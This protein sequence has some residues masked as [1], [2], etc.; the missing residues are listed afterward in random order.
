MPG[1]SDLVVPP[2]DEAPRYRNRELSWLDF[3][4]RV[5]A[6][7]EDPRVP[8]LERAKF[9]A[10]FGQNLVARGT[11]VVRLGDAVHISTPG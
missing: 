1:P 7:A 4:E 6:L 5:L 9:V 10:I 3:D 2:T 11:G 8:L